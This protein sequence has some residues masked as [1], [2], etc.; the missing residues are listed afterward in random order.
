MERTEIEW[1]SMCILS[2][3]AYRDEL[4]REKVDITLMDGMTRAGIRD[5]EFVPWLHV[6]HYPED[7]EPWFEPWW[8]WQRSIT[9][10]K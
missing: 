8:D 7:D 6:H 10:W 3:R 4:A 1:G 9:G 2:E 5:A